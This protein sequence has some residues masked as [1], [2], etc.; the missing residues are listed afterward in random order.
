MKEFFGL[1][2]KMFSYKKKKKKTIKKKKT[3]GYKKMGYRTQ[4]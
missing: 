1:W 2:L 4:D 3:K